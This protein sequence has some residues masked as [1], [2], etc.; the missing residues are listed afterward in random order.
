MTTRSPVIGAMALHIEAKLRTKNPVLQVLENGGTFMRSPISPEGL[1]QR[2]TRYPI[3]TPLIGMYTLEVN[4]SDGVSG[5]PSA[6]E[7][8]ISQW[9]PY[10]IRWG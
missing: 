6:Y 8:S 1:I 4:V 3:V 2:K 10:S 7:V 9:Q 5:E